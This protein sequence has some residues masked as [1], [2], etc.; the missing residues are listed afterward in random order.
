MAG[1]GC[2]KTGPIS[3]HLVLERRGVA[4]GQNLP[5]LARIDN[6]SSVKVNARVVLSQ[7]IIAII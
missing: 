6:Q 1:R 2:C 5:F 7:V 4:V 3:G